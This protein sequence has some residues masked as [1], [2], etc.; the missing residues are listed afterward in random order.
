MFF[1]TN[2]AS[3]SL[4]NNSGLY[5]SGSAVQERGNEIVVSKS[6]NS[7]NSFDAELANFDVGT[8]ALEKY[9]ATFVL[10]KF[11]NSNRHHWF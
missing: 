11:S 1:L 7:F 3:S 5:W 6:V 4:K 9:D 10:G 2:I 8:A